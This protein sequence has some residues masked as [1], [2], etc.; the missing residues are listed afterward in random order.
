MGAHRFAPNKDLRPG[1]WQPIKRASAGHPSCRGIPAYLLISHVGD[2][3]YCS[4]AAL[5]Q[6]QSGVNYQQ[7]WDFSTT[8]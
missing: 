2:Q 3:H 5:C 4:E 7:E 8:F 1:A 6:T